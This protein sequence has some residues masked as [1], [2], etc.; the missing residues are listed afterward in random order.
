MTGQGLQTL[1]S[2]KNFD[3]CGTLKFTIQGT[4]VF[5][6]E[7]RTS[8]RVI[9]VFVKVLETRFLYKKQLCAQIKSIFV[10]LF[11]EN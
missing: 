2:D 5:R 11:G 8:V 10:L 7:N 6:H 9:E 3:S 4:A 1:H